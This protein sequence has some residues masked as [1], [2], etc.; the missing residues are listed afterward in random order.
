M[1][2]LIPVAFVALFWV[3]LLLIGAC[4]DECSGVPDDYV[5]A[6]DAWIVGA[7]G[8]LAA[9]CVTRPRVALSVASGAF[10]VTLVAP[11][12]GA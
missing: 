9:F 7:T 12:V 5:V 1:V 4:A 3:G 11:F 8:W 10:L 2:A 6:R